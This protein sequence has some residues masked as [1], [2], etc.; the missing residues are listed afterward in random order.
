MKIVKPANAL[1]RQLADA[2]TKPYHTSR[3]IE[4]HEISTLMF[5]AFA[6]GVLLGIFILTAVYL[7]GGLQ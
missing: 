2:L 7:A 3:E 6:V 5:T 1:T 4:D